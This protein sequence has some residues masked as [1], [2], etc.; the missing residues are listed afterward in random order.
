MNTVLT[1]AN[2]KDEV[3]SGLVLV[4]FLGTM[5]WSM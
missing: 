2:F 1:D 4:D 3:A 5:V